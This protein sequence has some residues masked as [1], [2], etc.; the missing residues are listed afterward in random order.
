ML[1][2]LKISTTFSNLMEDY[3]ITVYKYFYYWLRFLIIVK[4][5]IF[6]KITVKILEYKTY[7]Y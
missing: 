3:Q 2:F 7:K 6:Y 5:E 1:Y 4:F